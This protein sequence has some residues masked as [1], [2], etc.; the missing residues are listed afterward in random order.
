[1]I[2]QAR[3]PTHGPAEIAGEPS[4]VHPVEREL[5][6]V[7][8]A[9][10]IQWE[11]EPH[12]LVLERR[13]D[14]SVKEAFT[15]DFFLPELGIYVECTVMRQRLTNRKRRKALKARALGGI[16]VEILFRRDL[17]RLASRW[18]LPGLAAAVTARPRRDPLG[19]GAPRSGYEA[20]RM[21]DVVRMP[22]AGRFRIDAEPAADG[23]VLLA[24]R[25]DADLHVAPELRDR[26]AREIEDGASA[27]VLDLSGAT[28]VDSMALGV[29]LG[30]M[31]RLRAQGGTLRLVVPQTELRRIFE[32]TLLDR[33]LPLD[34]TREDA[35]RE[36]RRAG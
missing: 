18:R 33:V 17:E 32:I 15:P 29:L 6:R 36:I 3:R 16:T 24:I 1:V 9:L 28:F 5:A 14:G 4:F 27:L 2:P 31:K 22:E 19:L 13:D 35:L 23:V 30:A 8:D 20:S 12:T 7:F 11:Y 25:G 26:L 34:A 21:G 10:G